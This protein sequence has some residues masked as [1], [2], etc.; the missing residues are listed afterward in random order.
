MSDDSNIDFSKARAEVNQTMK[1]LDLLTASVEKLNRVRLTDAK[2]ALASLEAKGAV[3]LEA[4]ITKTFSDLNKLEDM[5]VKSGDKI[6]KSSEKNAKELLASVTLS[7]NQIEAAVVTHL[8][9]VNALHRRAEDTKLAQQ[10]ASDAKSARAKEAF[11]DIQLKAD[12]AFTAASI[13]EAKRRADAVLAQENRARVGGRTNAFGVFISDSQTASQAASAGSLSAGSNGSASAAAAR[14]R[15]GSTDALGVYQNAIP[16]TKDIGRVGDLSAKFKQLSIDGNDVHSMARGLASGFNLLWLTWGNLVPLF[17]G[18][19]ISFGLKKT[20]DI[21]SE[22]EYLIKHMEVLGQTV[23]GLGKPIE[24][25]GSAIRQELRNIDQ[26]TLFTMEDLAKAMVRLGQAGQTPAEA[27][28]TLR[29]AAD[30]AAVGMTDLKTAT[31][32]LIQTQALF[33]LS[34]KDSTK[35]AAQIFQITKSGVLNVE[36]IAG[37]MKYA[38]EANTRFGKSLEETLAILGSLAKANLKGPSGGTALINFYRDINGRSGPAIKALKELEKATKSTIEVFKADGT[39]RSGVDI[40]TDIANASEKLK[41]KDAD[42][43]LANFFSDRGGRAFFSMIREG[44]I[45]HKAMVSTLENTDPNVLFMSA[46]GLMDTTKGAMNV[47]QGALVG[48]L[49]Q[50][51]EAYSSGFK[52]FITDVTAIVSSDNFKLGVAGMVDAVLSLYNLIK[53]FSSELILFFEVWAGFKVISAGIAIFQTLAV[54]IATASTTMGMGVGAAYRLTGA[55]AA[56][57]AAT[58]AHA[59]AQ[60]VMATTMAATTVRAT[61]AT[62][63]MRG[64]AAIAAFLANPIVGLVTTVGL[65]AYTFFS[66]EGSADTAMGG[67]ADSV[68]KNGKIIEGQLDREIKKLTDRNNLLLKGEVTAEDKLLGTLKD[69]QGTLA[70]KYAKASAAAEDP[71]SS[72]QVAKQAKTYATSLLAEMT[73]NEKLINSAAEKIEASRLAVVKKGEKD[74][75]DAQAKADKEAA[76]RA[77]EAAAATLKTAG[78]GGGRSPRERSLTAATIVDNMSKIKELGNAELSVLQNQYEKERTLLEAMHAAKLDS[79]GTYRAKLLALT[80]TSEDSRIAKINETGAKEL[81]EYQRLKQAHT[82]AT[83][84]EIAHIKANEG[85]RAEI[86]TQKRNALTEKLKSLDDQYKAVAATNAAA[87]SKIEEDKYMRM[88]KAAYS[89]AGV[90]NKIL[91]DTR[92]AEEKAAR[93]NSQQNRLAELS[94]TYGMVTSATMVFQQAE[95]AAAEAGLSMGFQLEESLVSLNKELDR[96]NQSMLDFVTYSIQAGVSGTK[97][98]EDTVKGRQERINA[99]EAQ[100]DSIATT[101]ARDMALAASRAYNKVIVE[102]VLRLK[103]AT[104]DALVTALFEGG[105]AGATKLRAIVVAELRKPITM[106]INAVVNTLWGTVTG[107]MGAGAGSGMASSAGGSLLSSFGSSAAGSL[108]G[109]G[110]TMA[111]TAYNSALVT[112]AYGSGSGMAASTAVAEAMGLGSTT[113]AGAATFGSMVATAIPYVAAAVAAYKIAKSLEGG[114]KRAGATYTAGSKGE[115]LFNQGPSGGEISADTSR[116]LFTGTQST[117]NSMLASFGSTATVSGYT[118]GLESSK[119]G[120]GFQFAGGYVNG[121]GFGEYLGREGG[122]FTMQTQDE[123]TALKNY[124]TDLQRSVLQALDAADLGGLVG[125]WIDSLGDLEALTEDQVNTAM[126]EITVFQQLT[127]IL[128]ALPFEYLKNITVKATSALVAAAGGVENLGSALGTYY[129]LFTTDAEKLADKSKNTSEAFT[130]VGL[131]MPTTG[132]REWYKAQVANAGAQ[133]LSVEANSKAYY[134][135][136]KL[137]GSVDELDKAAEET[138]TTRATWQEKLDVLLKK[139]TQEKVDLSKD[140]AS[141]TDESTKAIIRQVYAQEA[142]TAAAEKAAEVTKAKKTWQEKLDVLLGRTTQEQIDLEND[143]AST[144]DDSTKALIRQVYAQEAATASA[145]KYTETVLASLKAQV[146]AGEAVR[147]LLASLK[148]GVNAGTSP[149]SRLDAA[150]TQYL[151]DLSSARN[152]DFEAYNRVATTAQTYINAGAEMY[153]SSADQKAILAQVQSE[154][155]GLPAVAKYDENLATL[156]RIEAAV[157]TGGSNTV[158][159][160]QAQQFDTLAAINSMTATLTS[161][162]SSVDANS[163]GLLTFDELKSGLSVGDTLT[164]QLINA[165]DTNGDGQIS[166]LEIIAANTYGLDTLAR[167]NATVNS[168]NWTDKAAAVAQFSPIAQANGWSL[169]QIAAAT[170]YNLV[171]IEALFAGSPIARGLKASGVGTSASAKAAGSAPNITAGPTDSAFYQSG[172]TDPLASAARQE[173]IVTAVNNLDWNSA[174]AAT[175][176]WNQAYWNNWSQADIATSLGYNLSDIEALFTNAGLPKFAAGGTHIGGLR[177][178]GENGPELEATGPSR[179]WNASD[180]A[181]MLRGGRDDQAL[182]EEVRELRKEVAR[183]RDTVA[184]IHIH[185]IGTDGSKIKDIVIR[186]VKER[187]KRGEKIIYSSGIVT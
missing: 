73:K 25:M 40:F 85:Q 38:S 62:S 113:A 34:S 71:N 117:I 166:K 2:A 14:S 162:F 150:R 139:T 26:T 3:G 105:K 186:D 158:A 155:T 127:P 20:F 19:S 143:L 135:I 45:D 151:Q 146:S 13:A 8:T 101:G 78:S 10:Q 64:M 160:I 43:L 110:A 4:S 176:M 17:A 57:T 137:A 72:A 60:A 161:S 47:L 41:A 171:D 167:I 18:A 111:G 36:D 175:T 123:G 173:S 86:V 149:Q 118:A 31:D 76:R 54:A 112:S 108:L 102:D 152:G 59:E 53:K 15:I 24:G 144:T 179:I 132:L 164:Q 163:N 134:S 87:I 48:S 22:I 46:K 35:I 126:K 128:K 148:T 50:V 107:N 5:L 145:T 116:N 170:G 109:S 11:T 27:L 83:E 88:Q 106:M 44:T 52:D 165:I 182:V 6:K 80:T 168:I 121:K 133:D 159:A 187:S 69:A 180:T 98:Y 82:E 172:S 9:G 141:T 114:E 90:V 39:Q 140:L 65:L 74:R 129:S 131:S 93:V 177:L 142:A 94:Q 91:E 70:E 16:S 181:N 156:K 115:A 96:A 147:A 32:L 185:I 58:I 125:S 49:D 130:Q 157:T 29:P 183:A 84:F 1:S 99:L 120:K 75:L 103:N 178:V 56:A 154:L 12:R 77:A 33:G 169:Q 138:A 30:L 51:F 81:A 61:L 66:L 68:V 67:T 89:Y 92:I 63:A 153:A 28:Q 7:F 37:S 21:G 184:P 95:K 124:T 136:L 97:D 174:S 23:D 55:N 119:N 79:E 100:R 104:T 42:K 122:Q